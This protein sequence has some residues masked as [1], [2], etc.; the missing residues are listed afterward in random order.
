MSYLTLYF[1]LVVIRDNIQ[2]PCHIDAFIFKILNIIATSGNKE[3]SDLSL[4]N[5]I[6]QK[7]TTLLQPQLL[8]F[9]VMQ[10]MLPCFSWKYRI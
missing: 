4:A 10:C 5:H 6:K 2:P 9:V 8:I 1:S 3:S 7:L